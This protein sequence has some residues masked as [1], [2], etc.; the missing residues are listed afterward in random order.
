MSYRV[1]NE[2]P[3]KGE[4]ADAA[5]KRVIRLKSFIVALVVDF[6]KNRRYTIGPGWT[7]KSSM[8]I[9]KNVFTLEENLKVQDSK[10][11]CRRH[12]QNEEKNANPGWRLV[13]SLV[14]TYENRRTICKTRTHRTKPY[15]IQFFFVH[16]LPNIK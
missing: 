4:N 14:R 5:E 13:D 8:W 11:Y 16:V 3:R 12:N 9:L 10:N 2:D 6:D 1:D 7:I 15:L